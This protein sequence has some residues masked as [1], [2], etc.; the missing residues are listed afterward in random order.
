MFRLFFI[1]IT[2]FLAGP[3]LGNS[4]EQLHSE[5]EQQKYSRAAKTGLNILRKQPENIEAQFLTALSFQ[6]NGQADIAKRY[7]EEIIK[8]HPELPEPRNNLAMIYME[9][10]KY[11]QAIDLLV[12][13]L[14]THPA[15]ATAWQNLNLLYQGLASE[16]YRKA[17]GQEKNPRSVMSKIKLSTLSE[18]YDY[19]QEEI[20][21]EAKPVQLAE[22]SKP[23]INTTKPLKIEPQKTTVDVIKILQAWASAWSNQ[24]IDSYINAYSSDYRGKKTN[25][26]A[27][28]NYR[29][30]RI[31]KPDSIEIK[32]SD[33]KIKSQ[34]SS[35]AII[36]FNQSF[37]SSNYSDKVIKQIHLK[38]INGNWKITRE[39]TV[40]VL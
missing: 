17:L 11:D 10:G 13:S 29:R 40:D 15:Y 25:H 18:L 33:F 34:T 7:Y 19:Q 8:N 23:L 2:V 27:W 30:V 12:A 6:N 20:V 14:K 21:T 26:Q 28:I 16:A 3:V 22:N 39:V 4:I 35:L 36:N 31:S 5:L 1:L 38:N 24:D 32:L 37:K 9:Q